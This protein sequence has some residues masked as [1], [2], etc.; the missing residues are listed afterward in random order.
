MQQG[1]LGGREKAKASL[2][3]CLWVVLCI[4][5]IE[6]GCLQKRS[7]AD[8]VLA[9]VCLCECGARKVAWLGNV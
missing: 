4:L 8:D 7:R 6:G 3:Q 1:N 2:E 5:E 9:A